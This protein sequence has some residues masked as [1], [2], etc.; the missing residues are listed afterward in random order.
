MM[1][2]ILGA[3]REATPQAI[4]L[5]IAMQL[6]NVARDVLEDARHNRRYLPATWLPTSTEVLSPGQIVSEP[7][8]REAVSIAIRRLLDLADLYY[9]SAAPG[10]AAI[11]ARSR[12]AIRI[13]AA[14]YREIGVTV[15]AND[16]RWWQ[17]RTHVPL[18]RKL[19]LA[20]AVFFGRSDL[21]RLPPTDL[22]LLHRIIADLPGV[23]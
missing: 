20:S 11:P 8:H 2:A 10:F 4:N 18:P 5:G 19:R 7:V 12:H 21:E 22:T 23:R 9:A 16:V 3:S 15:R 13:A 6:T 1:S 17:G 14:V